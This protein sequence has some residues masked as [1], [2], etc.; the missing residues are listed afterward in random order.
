VVDVFSATKEFTMVQI[1]NVVVS[2]APDVE[3]N[4]ATAAWELDDVVDVTGVPA[5]PFSGG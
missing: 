2:G 1:I 5:V 3:L 4:L